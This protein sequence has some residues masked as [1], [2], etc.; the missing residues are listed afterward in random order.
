MVIAKLPGFTAEASLRSIAAHHLGRR[1]VHT[2]AKVIPAA[3]RD[4]TQLL[5]SSS[6]RQPVSEFNCPFG[7]RPTYVEGERRTIWCEAWAL[8]CCDEQGK[9]YWKQVRWECGWEFVSAHWECQRPP[10]RVVS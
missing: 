3:Q 9:R 2:D 6:F 1:A 4:W 5:G 7:T 10:F 8:V